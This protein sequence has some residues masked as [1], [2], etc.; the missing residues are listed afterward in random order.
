M[1]QRDNFGLPRIQ[2]INCIGCREK[3]IIQQRWVEREPNDPPA[4]P[5]CGEACRK[6]DSGKRRDSINDVEY[7]RHWRVEITSARRPESGEKVASD[8]YV[9]DNE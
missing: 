9:P 6:K 7:T 4:C 1:A 3:L 5:I 2:E 8:F